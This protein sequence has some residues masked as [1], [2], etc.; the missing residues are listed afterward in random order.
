M[1][2]PHCDSKITK[3]NKFCPECGMA[4]IWNVNDNSQTNNV[5][6]IRALIAIGIL[7]LVAIIIV[8]ILIIIDDAEHNAITNN[9][10]PMAESAVDRCLSIY[11]K[12]GSPLLKDTGCTISG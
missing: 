11:C 12:L 2:C 5:K 1:R 4:V 10:C 3:K 6:G 9:T 8:G 7:L